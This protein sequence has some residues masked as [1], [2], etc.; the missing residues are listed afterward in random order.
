MGE[1]TC[2]RKNTMYTAR[3][4]ATAAS[5]AEDVE[6][7]GPPGLVQRGHGLF[8]AQQRHDVPGGV[9]HG[10]SGGGVR[11]RGRGVGVE[12]HRAPLTGGHYPGHLVAIGGVHVLRRIAEL[13]A[14]EARVRVDGVVYVGAGR[15]V[16]RQLDHVDEIAVCGDD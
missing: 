12:I 8:H 13:I 4:A 14:R 7:I 10:D 16:V 2:L 9:L 1:T 3:K 15:V 6:H 5:Y 11:A